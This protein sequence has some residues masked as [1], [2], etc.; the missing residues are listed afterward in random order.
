MIRNAQKV[1]FLIIFLSIL[2]LFLLYLN[3][4]QK[5]VI[6][7]KASKNWFK[8][9]FFTPS[10]QAHKRSR[11]AFEKQS[12]KNFKKSLKPEE[13]K[14]LLNKTGPQPRPVSVSLGTPP[15]LPVR[16]SS[17]P[18]APPKISQINTKKSVSINETPRTSNKLDA[19]KRGV[20]PEVDGS[21]LTVFGEKSKDPAVMVRGNYD[22][23]FDRKIRGSDSYKSGI[24]LPVTDI[25]KVKVPN[26][27]PKK[28]FS[29]FS[30]FR[31]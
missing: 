3:D 2:I 22:Q 11:K 1:I 17:L 13:Q 12:L 25:D 23:I 4:K 27:V 19:P 9:F 24:N 20:E 30:W 14:A 15:P 10:E 21:N 29:P 6:I 31:K 8:R 26:K 16:S 18:P 5:S 28:L 7:E